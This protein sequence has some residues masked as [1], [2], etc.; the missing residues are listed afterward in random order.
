MIT[1]ILLGYI[2]PLILLIVAGYLIKNF[3]DANVIKWVGIAVNAAEQIYNSSGMGKENLLMFP[4]GFQRN[5]KSR[6]P[7]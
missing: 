3:R 4:N 7:T 6:K 1:N 2:L 5:S